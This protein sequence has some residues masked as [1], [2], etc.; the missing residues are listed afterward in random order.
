MEVFVDPVAC[1]GDGFTYERSVIEDHFQT[2][3]NK[4]LPLTSPKTN[5]TITTELLIPNN[6]VKKMCDAW[7]A[8]H[9]LS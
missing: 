9:T 1:A 2:R 6:N 8:T 3:K 5:A 4:N 7:K